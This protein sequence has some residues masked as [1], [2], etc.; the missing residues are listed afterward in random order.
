MYSNCFEFLTTTYDISGF[1]IHPV[2]SQGPPQA[3][4]PAKFCALHYV[5]V[6]FGSVRCPAPTCGRSR[7]SRRPPANGIKPV[8]GMG[9]DTGGG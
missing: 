5:W 6:Q 8:D 7:L 9:M 3:K 1:M 4:L 2:F